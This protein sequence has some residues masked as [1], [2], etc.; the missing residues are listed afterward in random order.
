MRLLPLLIV[1]VAVGACPL[2][3]RDPACKAAELCDAA[4]ESPFGDFVATDPVF[5][6]TGTCWQNKDTAKPCVDQCKAFVTDQ[7]ALAQAQGNQAVVDACGGVAAGEGE[8]EGE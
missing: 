5:G 3:P 2:I 6:D 7:A 8:G 4:L 1:V